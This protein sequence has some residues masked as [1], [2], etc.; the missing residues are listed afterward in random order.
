MMGEHRQRAPLSFRPVGDRPPKSRP[1]QPR[2]NVLVLVHIALIVVS[3]EL[4]AGGLTEDDANGQKEQS[5]DGPD[6][7]VAGPAAGGTRRIRICRRTCRGLDHVAGWGTPAP[8]FEP[9]RIRRDQTG[10]ISPDRISRPPSTSQPAIRC[11]DQR[12]HTTPP[13]RRGPKVCFTTPDVKRRNE[14][15]G[16]ASDDARSTSDLSCFA[17]PGDWRYGKPCR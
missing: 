17:S 6:S 1:G 14:L 10:A 16:L 13:A 12:D 2:R 15:Y 9:W 4:V 3:D 7:I 5:A 11:P 8:R